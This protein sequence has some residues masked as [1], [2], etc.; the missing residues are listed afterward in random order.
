V[1]EAHPNCFDN[2]VTNLMSYGIQ[3]SKI[4]IPFNIFMNIEISRRGEIT[5]Q[6]PLSKAG[7]YVELRAEMNMIVGVTA[8]S[9]GNCNNF[10][11]TPIDVEVYS[12]EVG[13]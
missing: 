3:A 13:L 9:A 12:G 10:K 11:W 2:L 4:N 6:P 7:D 5:I 8:C 1:I